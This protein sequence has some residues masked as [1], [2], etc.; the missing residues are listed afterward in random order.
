MEV[1]QLFPIPVLKTKVPLKYST[2]FP[3]LEKIPHTIGQGASQHYGEKSLN[4]YILE[5]PEL[6]DLKQ[7]ILDTI[8]VFSETQLHYKSNLSYKLTQSWTTIKR[9][10]QQHLMHSHPNSLISGVFYY[11]DIV[12]STPS[13]F[14]ARDTGTSR[15]PL[16]SHPYID[17]QIEDSLN[18]VNVFTP[19][20]TLLIFPSWLRHGVPLNTTNV[21]RK[22][23]AF[24]SVPEEGF[25]EIDRLTRLEF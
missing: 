22:S 1:L 14:F 18:T 8:N 21:S 7:Y 15:D 3:F 20:G 24:N 9:P 11:G 4:T 19:P 10:G 13:I 25:G 6:T 17:D 2:V 12:P 16:I 5:L 23:L